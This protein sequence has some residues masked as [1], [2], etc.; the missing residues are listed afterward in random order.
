MPENEKKY[1]V[2][3]VLRTVLVM[4]LDSGHGLF[5]KP[6]EVRE[7]TKLEVESPS[8]RKHIRLKRLRLLK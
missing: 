2:K 3:N 7:L 6:H 1:R 4:D 5:L 8:V